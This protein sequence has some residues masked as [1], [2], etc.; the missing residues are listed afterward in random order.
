MGVDVVYIDA[1][2]DTQ[3]VLT[4][5]RAARDVCPRAILI[6]DDWL[7]ET[8]QAAVRQFSEEEGS[9][10]E[11]V[12]NGWSLGTPKFTCSRRALPESLPG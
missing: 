5:L 6:G 7:W 2:H 10:I 12:E 3:S 4:D 11:A 8:V 1:S 9:I